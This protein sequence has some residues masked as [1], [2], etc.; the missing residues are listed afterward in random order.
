MMTEFRT[1][2]TEADVVLLDRALRA[3]S[4]DLGDTHEAGLDALRAALTGTTPAAYG[5]LAWDG[6][7]VGAAL[8][9]PVFSTARGAAG[10]YVSDLWVDG[11]TRGQGVGQSILAEIARR[12]GKLWQAEWMTL[13][14]YGHS[15]A[16]RRFYERLG[17]APQESVTQMRLSQA[18]FERLKGEG[19]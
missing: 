19:R 7:V 13:A 17:F 6:D 12:A 2:T 5:L 10:V 15:T 8:Y 1:V 14:V 4:H 18:G 3:L 16:A 11:A 9:S